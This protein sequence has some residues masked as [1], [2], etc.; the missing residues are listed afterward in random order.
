MTEVLN[1]V[2][3]KGEKGKRQGAWARREEGKCKVPS[4]ELVF[5]SSR[6]QKR[7]TGFLNLGRLGS[8]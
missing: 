3:L 4:E 8:D 2:G 5:F 6:N 7:E 1:N